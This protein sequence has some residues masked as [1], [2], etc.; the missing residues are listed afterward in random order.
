MSLSN[1]TFKNNRTGETLRV[2]DSFEDLAILENKGKE[3][4]SNLLN[5]DLYTEQIDVSNFFN[6]HI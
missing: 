6:N 4:V 5:P 2:I 1:K 3:K